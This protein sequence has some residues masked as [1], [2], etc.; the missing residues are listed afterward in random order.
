MKNHNY[1]FAL[2]LAALVIISP[3]GQINP[4]IAL[5]AVILSGIFF[6]IWYLRETDTQE[7]TEG[8]VDMEQTFYV[9]M[10]ICDYY[11]VHIN[12]NGY[13]QKEMVQENEIDGFVHCLKVLGYKEI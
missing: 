2:S 5:G 7:T 11:A 1:W 6:A 12:D 10:K 13:E 3:F 4:L 9:G 8:V